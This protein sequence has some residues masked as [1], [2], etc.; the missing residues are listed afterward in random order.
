MG[1][2]RGIFIFLVIFLMGLFSQGKDPNAPVTMINSDE[3][4][5]DYYAVCV[6][7][8]IETWRGYTDENTLETM[9]ESSGYYVIHRYDSPIDPLDD[10]CFYWYK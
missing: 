2:I 4:T 5:G 10:Y 6:S 3:P 9:T 7:E 8:G 1:I